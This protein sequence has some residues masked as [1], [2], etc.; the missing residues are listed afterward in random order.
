MT[1]ESWYREV[2]LP[3]LLR[4]ARGT[5]GRAMRAALAE[6]GCGDIPAN[7][8]YIIGGLAQEA[9]GVPIGKLVRD[10]GITKQGAGQLVD[11]LV[12]RGYLR[13]TPDEND[14]RQLLVTLTERGMAAAESLTAA[15]VVVDA[16]LLARVGATDLEAARRT[17]AALIVIGRQNSEE[18]ARS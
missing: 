15:R 8:L 9:G 14:R 16:T 6:A 17:L 2:S 4:H 3:A 11:T 7:G 12:L 13:R 5:Y 10:L 18:D 1:N